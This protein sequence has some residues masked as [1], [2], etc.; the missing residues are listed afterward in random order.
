MFILKFDIKLFVKAA[1]SQEEPLDFQRLLCAVDL[2]ILFNT[3]YL[4]R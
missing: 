2:V 1:E 4:I 3:E